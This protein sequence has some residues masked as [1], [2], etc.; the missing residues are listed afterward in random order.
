MIKRRAVTLVFVSLLLAVGAA[1]VANTWLQSR[2][3]P[4]VEA[5]A[6]NP[7]VVAA[8]EIP[9]GFKIDATRIKTVNMP[10]A[11][12]PG[13]AFRSTQE[14]EGK[15][16]KQ[17]FVPGE[18]LI[19]ERVAEHLGGS[20][21]AAIVE[22]EMRAITVRVNDVVGV[23]GFV[24]PGNRVDVV[25][26]RR[27]GD[28]AEAKTVLQD[29]KVLAVDETASTDKN[30]P[31]IV[32]AVTLEMTPP[33]AEVLV[34]AQQEGTV[35]LTLRNPLDHSAMKVQ[36]AV[37]THAKAPVPG[38]TVSNTVTVIRGTDVKVTKAGL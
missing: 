4:A 36:A 24:L 33:Q 34:K 20:T 35:Q 7:V 30:D 6:D 1:W 13:G 38:R 23:G 12:V 31:V 11:A 8:M 26:S 3:M 28:R 22:P 19:K 2:V 18:V 25:A 16:A 9:F 32:R 14:V 5:N 29:L 21:L 15:I 10:P 37:H 17:T 27:V